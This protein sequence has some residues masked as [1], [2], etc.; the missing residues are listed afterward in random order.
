MTV[1]ASSSEKG[2]GQ[3]ALPCRRPTIARQ[4]AGHRAPPYIG[5]THRKPSCF[6]L[7]PVRSMSNSYGKCRERCYE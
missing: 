2:V 7:M 1:R 5:L 6:V 4:A 3:G